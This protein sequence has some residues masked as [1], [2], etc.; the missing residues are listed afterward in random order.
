MMTTLIQSLNPA[1]KYKIVGKIKFGV[2]KKFWEEILL[3]IL[4]LK[5]YR[6]NIDIFTVADFLKFIQLIVFIYW[7]TIGIRNS[8]KRRQ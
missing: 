4:K 8:H 2:G 6:I 3:Q 7:R 1:S 5:L